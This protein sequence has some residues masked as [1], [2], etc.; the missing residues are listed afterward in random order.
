[1]P[2]APQIAA[3]ERLRIE[4]FLTDYVHCIDDDELERWPT[5]FSPDAYYQIIPHESYEAGYPVGIMQCQGRGMMHDRVLALRSAN[6]YEPH[7][8]CHIT[9]RT[10]LQRRGPE[11]FRARTNFH[12]VRTMQNGASEPFVTGKYVDDISWNGD[13]ILL[14]DRRVVLDSHQIDILLVFP[15]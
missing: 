3:S 8:Y 5:F 15:L 14:T 10:G 1:M 6:I 11:Q 13:E 4:D 9:G 2:D 7:R 12:V